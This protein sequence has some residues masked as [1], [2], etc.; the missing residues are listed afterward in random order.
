[1]I[2]ND[3]VADRAAFRT[4]G[5]LAPVPIWT[6]AECAAI[7]ARLRASCAAPEW[8][9]GHAAASR[10]FFDAG[11][12]PR[13]AGMVALLLG[14]D[15]VLWGASLIVRRPGQAHRWHTD[16]ESSHP[17]GGMVSVWIGLEHTSRRSALHVAPGSHRFGQPLQQVF[18][19]AG[20]RRDAV[21]IDDVRG[22]ALARDPAAAPVEI[23]VT[24]GEGIV[25]YGRLWHGSLNGDP[26]RTRTA[27]LLQYAVP[28]TPVR[29]PDLERPEWPFHF[30]EDVRPPCV[31]VSGTATTGVNRVVPAPL[32]EALAPASAASAVPLASFGLAPLGHRIDRLPWPL[33]EDPVVGWRPHPLFRG[34]TPRLSLLN[35]HVS[36][37]GP[38]KSP[39]PI[40]AHVQEELLIVLDG[41]ADL[42]T[43]DVH[44]R[45]HTDRLG[46]GSLA[47]YPVFHPHTIRN[48]SARP[49]T[50]AMFKWTAAKPVV[51]ADELGRTIIRLGE[52]DADERPLACRVLFEGPTR[53]LAKLHAH[54]TTLK[55]GGGYD[56]HADPYDVAILTLEGEVETLGERV[57]PN[58]VIFYPAGDPHGMRNVGERRARYLV[59]ELHGEIGPEAGEASP[60]S[61]SRLDADAAGPPDP[62]ASAAA[63]R[64]SWARP[65]RRWFKR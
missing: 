36:I 8:M 2:L 48:A 12:D 18:A 4:R 49:I 54:V 23:D 51:E 26:E 34:A 27:L 52:P 5:V 55:P 11:R 37:L 41:D 16:I 22:W 32:P 19:E 13:V 21:T 20:K 25:F 39:H 42:V 43:V 58:S 47:Y 64:G 3:V 31:V 44:D 59:L 28:S 46:R 29:I 61:V 7:L 63:P 17:S 35:A 57:G 56:P 1:M 15:V 14:P 45:E 60:H 33:P 62:A 9:K 50:Y 24:D 40:H 65:V 10:A 38:G 53:H 6:P 30:R